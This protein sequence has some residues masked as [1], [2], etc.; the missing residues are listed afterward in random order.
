MA[1]PYFIQIP[2]SGCATFFIFT[3]LMT[4]VLAVT[5]VPSLDV[6]LI[7]CF[8][9]QSNNTSLSVFDTARGDLIA[10]TCG[11]FLKADIPIDFSRVDENGSGQFT[12]GKRRF[13]VHSPTRFSHRPQCSKILTSDFVVVQCSK[14]TWSVE[15]YS[16]GDA[17]NCFQ[18]AGLYTSALHATRGNQS[19]STHSGDVI[20]ASKL[21]KRFF[22]HTKLKRVG[23][24]SIQRFLHKQLSEPIDCRGADSC[25]ASKQD[26]ESFSVSYSVTGALA[27]TNLWSSFGLSVQKTWTTGNQYTCSGRAGD[28]V[29]IWLIER[30]V[31]A[32]KKL[33]VVERRYYFLGIRYMSS[34][35]KSLMNS[36][37]KENRG[38]GYYCVVNNCMNKGDEFWD[39]SGFGQ[40]SIDGAKS[41]PK[42]NITNT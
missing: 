2:L 4:A 24:R 39:N 14:M 29:C 26:A 9:K 22:H 41:T 37:N 42:Q 13:V 27:G 1:Y 7:C 17:S 34:K 31:K 23:D 18:D 40:V 33:D 25:T 32:N 6:D 38:G 3:I 30:M 16:Q 15:N 8:E 36:P 20:E 19:Y 10:E 28:S 12:I 5:E 21:K 35:S 11:S